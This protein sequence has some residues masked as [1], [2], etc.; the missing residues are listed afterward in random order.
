VAKFS[1]QIPGI[2]FSQ[3]EITTEEIGDDPNGPAAFFLDLQVV[4]DRFLEAF[5]EVGQ[6]G[7]PQAPRVERRPENQPSSQGDGDKVLDEEFACPNC[8][9]KAARSIE[10][11]QQWEMGNDGRL[12]A[13]KW[14]CGNDRCETKSL[15]RSKLVP[16]VQPF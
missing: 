5:P 3:W 2:P 9:Q 1:G 14:F 11:Y 15:W 12:Y 16:L 10:K 7:A 13:Q 4:R 8:N 6:Q